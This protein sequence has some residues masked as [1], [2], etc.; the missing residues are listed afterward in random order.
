MTERTGGGSAQPA[1]STGTESTGARPGLDAL[2]GRTDDCAALDDMVEAIRQGLSRSLVIVGEAGI[3]KTRLLRYAAQVAGGLRTVSI[4][5]VESEFRLG[6]AAL[7]RMLVPFLDRIGRL[8]APQR[9]ALGS[10][11]GLSTGPPA[12]RFLV[13]LGALT[14]LADAAAE[15]PLIWMVDDAQWLDRES[16]EVLGFV[17]RRLYAD[18][19]G[20]LFGAREPSPGLTA[21]DGLPTRRLDGLDPAA[22]RILLATSVSGSVNARVAARLI[23]ETGGNPLALL[24]LAGQLSAA[25]LAGRSPLPQRLPV[26]RRM[27]G[28]F[29]RQVKTLPPAA[30]L[31]LLLA[32]AASSD[33]PAALW[34][35]AALLDLG[36]DAADPAVAQEIIAFHP[37]VAFRHPLIRSAVY[38]GAR[39]GDRRQV[40]DALANIASRDG[41]PDQAAWH[42]AAA[43]V[44]PDEDVAADLERSAERAE[45]RGGY[46]AQATFLARAAE[47]TPGPR[48]RAVRLFAAAQAHLAAGDGTLAQTLLDLAAPDLAA[49]GMRVMAQR[50]RAS[51]A[52]FFSRH[53]DAPAI[54]LGAAAA[55]DPAEVSL[56]RDMLFEAMQAALVAGQY[57]TGTT[58]AEVAHAALRAPRE[59]APTAGATG[60]LLDGFATRSAIGYPPA[61]PLLR[62]AVAVLF[63]GEETVP[64]DIPAT[65]LG[66]FAADDLWDDRGRR[67]MLGR[68]E[69]VQRRHGAL[70]ALRITLA[71]LT[72]GEVWAGRPADA[73]VRYL[74][75]AEISS[76]IGVP[77]PATTGVLLELR[78]WQGRE[79]ESRMLAESTAQW[80]R[81]RGAA[82]LEV[83]A[84][85]GL[86]VLELGL[87]R[88]A[89][90]L[91]WGMR[92]YDEDPPGFGNRILPEIVEAG[93]RGGDLAA[94]HAALDRLAD[95][96]TASGTPWALGMLARSRALLARDTDAETFYRDAIAHLTGTLVR[97]E[98][99]RAHLLYG[100]WLRRRKRRKD[101]RSQL[102][103]ACDMFDAMDAAAF[104]RRSRAELLAAGDSPGHPTVRPGPDL[105]PQESQVARL[106][107]VGTTN[108]EIATHL[109]VTISTVEYHLTKVFR[110][111]DITSR[112]Q[113]AA[114]LA[115]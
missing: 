97:T 111:L 56:I 106:A 14:L 63:T 91:D 78:A 85:M 47:L 5:G 42:R 69:A 39:S 9:D 52:V 32:S 114:A 86:T 37:R 30:S 51:I 59:P 66:W 104:A 41:D 12:D 96:A 92:I 49:T 1:A 107:A 109:F 13:G 22:A 20:L 43:A 21:L 44:V 29:L 99:A 45:R 113:L 88:Y 28:H 3:G 100:E 6:F 65:I 15:Q 61:V 26:G 112:R 84:F 101:A 10:A 4:A 25:Q 76:S 48:E 64:A 108:A 60:M 72:T 79:Q 89:E 46:A 38:E 105:T 8:P 98:L 73:E 94:A 62:A 81:Q 83:F 7:H 23:S 55:A 82:V 67:A 90:A 110:K 31:V 95:R 36:P 24:E 11:F 35:A 18:R 102:R 71:G 80:G 74:Q 77:P 40:H 87:G 33:D 27:Q 115:H 17:G 103:T 16:L 57:T 50:L 58:P 93:A 70:G 34:R 54:L 68:A 75:A 19:I 2:V 53:K